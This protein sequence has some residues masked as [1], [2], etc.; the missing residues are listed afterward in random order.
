M[1]C[2]PMGCGLPHGFGFTKRASRWDATVQPH[3]TN[4]VGIDYR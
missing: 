4:P 2:I 1:W 3:L